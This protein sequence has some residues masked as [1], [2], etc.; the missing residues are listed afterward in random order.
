MADKIEFKKRKKIKTWLRKTM[1]C[2]VLPAYLAFLLI[3][4]ITIC[5][6]LVCNLPNTVYEVAIFVIIALLGTAA[7]FTVFL[8]IPRCRV[9]QAML[10]LQHYDFTPYEAKD[11]ETYLYSAATEKYY[12]TP[13]PFDDDEGTVELKDI[14]AVSDY[15]EQF[16]PERLKRMD[17]LG[18]RGD[19]YPFY[20]FDFKRQFITHTVE[21]R[22]EGDFITVTVTEK[23]ELTFE[24]DG[25][26]IG[27]KV[28]AYEEMDA[29]V[30]AG[31][32][33]RYACFAMTLNV[34]LSDELAVGFAFGTRIMSIADKHEIKI[35]AREIADLI[36]SDPKAAFK[37]IALHNRLKNPKK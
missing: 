28:F 13:S 36:L 17:A 35:Q 32:I 6:L 15:F 12:F 10:D 7:L 21:K 4:G 16:T 20:V 27:E 18:V 11:T 37:R 30:S 29:F 24:E 5:I 19:F 25:I 34:A 3:I 8:I 23:C 2:V 33:Q 26:H 9:K 22:R 14:E 1:L 31:F